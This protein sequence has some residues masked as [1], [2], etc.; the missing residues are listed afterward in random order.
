[1]TAGEELTEIPIKI[2]NVTSYQDCSDGMVVDSS[3]FTQPIPAAE[4]S[5]FSYLNDLGKGAALWWNFIYIRFPF[6]IVKLI[7]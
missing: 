3:N 1:M 5:A 7:C 4:R 6:I 2:E